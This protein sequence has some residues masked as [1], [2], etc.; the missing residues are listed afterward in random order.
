MV[1]IG[2]TKQKNDTKIKV[3]T[4]VIDYDIKKTSWNQRCKEI[5]EELEKS[6]GTENEL[7]KN[8]EF[9]RLLDDFNKDYKDSLV[10]LPPYEG[11]F[12]GRE[13]E[14]KGIRNTISKT[15]EPTRVILGDAGTGKTTLVREATRRINAGLMENKM[16]YNLVCVELSLLAL[17][18]EGESKFTSMLAEII[19]RILKLEQ[20][21]RT[22]LNDE[23]IKFVLFIDEVHTLTKAV[24]KENGESNGADVLKR[25]IKPEIGTLILIGA[26]TLEEYRKYIEPNQPLKERFSDKTIL[27]EFTDKE[28]EKISLAHWDYLMSLRKIKNSKLPIEWIRYIIKTNATEDLMSSEPRKTK[29]FLGS[30][31]SHSFNENQVPTLD[32]IKEV[33]RTAKHITPEVEPDIEETFNAID[34]RLKGQY[35]AKYLAKRAIKARYGRLTKSYNKPYLSFLA[36]GPTGVG[37]TE[38]ANILNDNIFGGKGIIVDMICSDY[39]YLENGVEKFLREAGEKIRSSEYAIFLIDEVEKAIPSKRNQGIRSS[40]RDVFLEITGKGILKYSPKSG[41]EDIK[42]SLSK[43]IIVFTSNAG[44]EIFEGKEKFS[45]ETIT[46]NTPKNIIEQ[47]L[48]SVGDELEENLHAEYNFARE[49]FGRLDAVLPFTSLTE[50]D[51]IEITER[52]LEEVINLAYEQ[53]NIIIKIDDKIKYGHKKIRGL[54]EGEVR[55]FYPLAVTLSSYL[56]NMKKSSKGGAR[57]VARKFSYYIENILSDIKLKRK[58]LS[59]MTIVIYPQLLDPHTGER[60]EDKKLQEKTRNATMVNRKEDIEIVYE[61]V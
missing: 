15:L 55:E 5:K 8:E 42:V 56:S 52:M 35:A 23:N 2:A 61:E 57:Q 4:L 18:D 16:G 27:P 46:A 47:K 33:F 6:K 30:L 60:V 19:P 49:F 10:I 17:L 24:Q 31:D 34:T 9:H 51:A 12:L 44:Y 29:Q 50:A 38:F 59:E 20:E 14:L 25:H 53:E 1:T 45:N 7:I 13:K 22:L 26:T 58:D 28:V 11:D 40:L 32:M 41:G 39:A 3:S 48:Q 43:T 54:D 37:K 36:L 21:A